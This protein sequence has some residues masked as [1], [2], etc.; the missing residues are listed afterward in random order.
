MFCLL[1]CWGARPEGFGDW[2]EVI[3]PVK[4]ERLQLGLALASWI[5]EPG[6][7]PNSFSPRRRPSEPPSSLT[8][9]NFSSSVAEA[10]AHL[11]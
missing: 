3:Q 5:A 7:L 1:P 8:V 9:G 6:S 4:T 11:L 10:Y 2:V